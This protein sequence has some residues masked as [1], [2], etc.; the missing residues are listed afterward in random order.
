[1]RKINIVNNIPYFTRCLVPAY[2]FLAL[3]FCILNSCGKSGPRRLLYVAVPGIR[4]YVEYG[5]HGVIVFDID[6]GHR[7][8]KRIPTGSLDG[9]GHPINVKGICASEITDRLYVSTVK[10]LI[11]IDLKT[12][13][14]IWEREYKGGCDRMAISPDGQIIYLPTL[15]NIDGWKVINAISG[16]IIAELMPKSRSHN[17][18]YGPDGKEVYLA[19]LGSPLLSIADTA[20]HK[21]IRTV[22]PFSHNVRPFTINGAQTRVYVNING[23]LGFEIGDLKSGKVLHEINVPGF[24]KGRVK[25]HGCPSHGIG[26]TPDETRLWVSDGANQHMH[27]FDLTVDPPEYI[28][29]LQVRDDPGWVTFSIDGTLAYPS[30]G[31]VFDTKTLKLI[32]QLTDEKGQVVQSEKMLEIDFLGNDAILAGNQFGIG[33]TKHNK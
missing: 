17:T 12:D 1:M 14:I 13:K 29:S 16:D 15:H 32:T 8:V 2:I 18:I 25:R 30:S 4:N 6:D 21:I 22:G 10:H 7:F 23:R 28:K 19:G 31:D 5:G 27:V 9:K 20:T 33:Q 26:M 3:C 11:C 24:K